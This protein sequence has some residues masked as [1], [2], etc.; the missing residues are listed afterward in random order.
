M[1][2]QLTLLSDKRLD[3]LKHNVLSK[4]MHANVEV[5]K[6][7]NSGGNSTRINV[8]KHSLGKMVGISVQNLLASG[9][10]RRLPVSISWH[11]Y[12][13]NSTALTGNPLIDNYGKNDLTK[14]GESGSGIVLVGAEK[15]KANSLLAK[16]N[17]NVYASDMIPLNR[18]VPDA[19]FPG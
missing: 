1:L 8:D 19:R 16:Y 12:R 5:N 13:N 14:I 4:S 17:V 9:P 11:D 15:D 2:I 6:I 7:Y 10:L 3:F 18:M